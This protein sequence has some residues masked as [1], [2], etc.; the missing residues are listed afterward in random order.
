MEAL[1]TKEFSI[2]RRASFSNKQRSRVIVAT[3]V[4]R[5]DL[6]GRYMVLVLVSS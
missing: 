2:S 6:P 3:R 5:V 1:R 4:G